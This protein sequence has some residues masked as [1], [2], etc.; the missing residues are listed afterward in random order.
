[1]KRMPPPCG[2]QFGK[3]GQPLLAGESPPGP[4]TR[5]RIATRSLRP[6]T[7]TQRGTENLI[8]YVLAGTM[9]TV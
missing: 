7:L 5:I 8:R 1:M 3:T 2:E 6:A 9:G 4:R